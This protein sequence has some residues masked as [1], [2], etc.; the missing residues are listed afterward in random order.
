MNGRRYLEIILLIKITKPDMMQQKKQKNKKTQEKNSSTY[1]KFKF[2]YEFD[3]KKV[4]KIVVLWARL[5]KRVNE[6]NQKVK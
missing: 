5:K 4:W 2:Y 1:R 6:L 3:A